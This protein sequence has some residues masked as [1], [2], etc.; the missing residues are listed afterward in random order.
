MRRVLGLVLVVITSLL[1]CTIPATASV[2]YK[3]VLNGGPL[4]RTVTITDL[5]DTGILTRQLCS[6]HHASALTHRPAVRITIQWFRAAQYLTWTGRFYPASGAQPAA[7]DIPRFK[8]YIDTDSVIYCNQRIA[9]AG[10]L[11][12]LHAYHVPTRLTGR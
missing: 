3:I 2:P 11:V 7:I 5:R 12:V 4:S 8:L 10:A 9:G 6:P 1:C